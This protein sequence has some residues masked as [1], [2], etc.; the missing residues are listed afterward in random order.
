ME[1]KLLI[2][3]SEKSITPDR[4]VSL[5]GQFHSGIS[6]YSETQV[7]VNVISVE[8]AKENGGYGTSVISC[9]CDCT[10]GVTL[11]EKTLKIINSLWE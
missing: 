4:P 9:D 1:E 2:G 3:F 6:E 5:A 8:T 11:A 7:M 10:G